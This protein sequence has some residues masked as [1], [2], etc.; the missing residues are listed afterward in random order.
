MNRSNGLLRAKLAWTSDPSGTRAFPASKLHP[1]TLL[2]VHVLL[3]IAVMYDGLAADELQRRNVEE[4]EPE[5]FYKT[6]S[7]SE[8]SPGL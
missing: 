7:C 8:Y 6:R 4:D 1:I 3:H 2:L 5:R